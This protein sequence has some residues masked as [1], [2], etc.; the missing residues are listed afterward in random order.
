MQNGSEGQPW[1]CL[2][3]VKGATYGQELLY[4]HETE[5]RVVNEDGVPRVKWDYTKE[6]AG[7]VMGGEFVFFAP[8]ARPEYIRFCDGWDRFHKSQPSSSLSPFIAR[9]ARVA[10]NSA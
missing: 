2:P 9:N 5:C 1:H 3:F 7:T 6:P 4:P 8:R 10:S